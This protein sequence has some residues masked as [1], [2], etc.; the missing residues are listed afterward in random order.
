MDK[1][2]VQYMRMQVELIWRRAW[3]NDGAFVNTVTNPR[4]PMQR[5]ELFVLM[6]HQEVNFT[7]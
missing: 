3:R 1:R 2:Y 6:I 4:G 5:P 7:A